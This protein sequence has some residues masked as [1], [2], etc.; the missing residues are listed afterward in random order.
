MRARVREAC[1]ETH[2]H[3]ILFA[4]RVCREAIIC[5]AAFDMLYDSFQNALTI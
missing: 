3:P 1:G 5:P 4:F 2:Q